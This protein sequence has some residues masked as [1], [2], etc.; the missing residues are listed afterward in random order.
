[1][2]SKINYQNVEIQTLTTPQITDR[3]TIS[4][5]V[6]PNLGKLV[7]D[8]AGP[9]LFIG[10]GTNW[11]AVGG[12][13]GAGF[14]VGAPIAAL[15]NNGMKLTGTVLSAEFS[16]GTHNGIVSTNTQQWSGEKEFLNSLLSYRINLIDAGSN[17]VAG[18]GANALNMGS[19]SCYYGVNAGA[20]IITGA[21]NVCIGS[22]SLR[23]TISVNDVVAI[24]YK[25]L[26]SAT[27]CNGT[28][29]IGSGALQNNTVGVYNVAIGYNS[30]KANISG[31]S[32]VSVGYQSLAENLGDDN[33][34]LG[35]SAL[36]LNTSG[37][38]N[39]GI[40]S[41]VML[42]NDVGTANIGIGYNV[43]N[44]NISGN[45][46]IAIG[47]GAIMTS[48]NTGANIAIGTNS[49]G[50][51]DGSNIIAIGTNS[52]NLNTTGSEITAIGFEALKS[53]TSGSCLVAV[54]HLALTN[55]TT[56][57]Y[58]TAVGNGS[59]SGNTTGNRNTSLGRE[60][61]RDN[62][63]G[64]H[65]TA[66]GHIT[67]NV[68]NA[69]QNNTAIG[70]A[71]LANLLAGTDNIAIGFDS[72]TFYQGNETNNI[73]INNI[74]VLGDNDT[75]RIGT[76]QT[77]NFQAGIRGVTPD[78][79]DGQLVY[80]SSDGQ[81]CT[82]GTTL[83][84]P[85]LLG[86]NAGTVPGTDYI[87]ASDNK[88]IFISTNGISG[89]GLSLL[90]NG[91]VENVN[92]LDNVSFGPGAGNPTAGSHNIFIGKSAG[93]AYTSTNSVG[94]G[95]LSMDST[96]GGDGNTGIGSYTLR[97]VTGTNNTAVGRVAGNTITSSVN[98]CL[99]GAYAG[100]SITSGSDGNCIYGVASGS[101]LALG[102]NNTFFGSYTGSI[103]TAG[104]GNIFIGVN[105]GSNITTT[106][107]NILI[108]NAGVLGDSNFIRIGSGQVKN[109][110]SGIYG[111]TTDIGV[112]IPV[113]VSP[114]GQLGTVS[115]LREKKDG[116]VDV[117]EDLNHEILSKLIPRRFYMKCDKT[118]RLTYGMIVDE[119]IDIHPD[120]IATDLEGKPNTIIYS[121]I[122]I[123]LLKEVQR[124]NKVIDRLSTRIEFLEK[125]L[126][127]PPVSLVPLVSETPLVPLEIPPVDNILG[128]PP[129]NIL[130]D[131][132][133][134]N[135]SV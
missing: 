98:N 3:G 125:Y 35:Y 54:G 71:S 2:S 48:T 85:W 38:K 132:V 74:G 73:A 101:V 32:N 43:L 131:P 95:D 82:V 130:G 14:S 7:F 79:L 119:V 64:D 83:Y 75:T 104:S 112:A 89:Y 17:C 51:A 128:E 110:Q 60:S 10:D 84:T 68:A 1:M 42:N 129:D 116:I 30:Q 36:S 16:D 63:T 31:I 20:N 59:M 88:D 94:I 135:M 120:L 99:Y 22:E 90:T 111:V 78:V 105:S 86:G 25:S 41:N 109:F 72:G 133:S 121:D 77:R 127:I 11:I 8:L 18:V 66:I 114:S 39:I 55:N 26:F 117:D 65:N 122:S 4:E 6:T 44:M 47:N 33:I 100:Q 28:V 29:A 69:S 37:Q 57:L 45:D 115:S 40:G 123:M 27:G 23:N 108:A 34:A 80:V 124:C 49:M 76:S 13:S 96:V 53:N 102:S 61:L 70:S 106:S 58:N 19:D 107:N 93:H 62:Q 92:A 91:R 126:E 118:K 24:G 46:N 50:S 52:V 97:S 15:D 81:L 113:L 5:S 9:E 56:G 21:N 103:I 134:Q 67:L 12:G 87:G